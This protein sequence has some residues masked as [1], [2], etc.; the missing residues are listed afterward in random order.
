LYP[1]NS[2]KKKPF[3]LVREENT[4]LGLLIAKSQDYF[5]M[6]ELSF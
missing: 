2:G 4:G 1:E 3:S 6:D 5:L